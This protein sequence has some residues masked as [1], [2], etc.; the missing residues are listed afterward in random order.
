MHGKLCHKLNHAEPHEQPV[1]LELASNNEIINALITLGYT[2][3]VDQLTNP[4]CDEGFYP[5][6]ANKC[7]RKICDTPVIDKETLKHVRRIV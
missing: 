1:T 5:S 7:S 4:M 2:F 6:A 3:T